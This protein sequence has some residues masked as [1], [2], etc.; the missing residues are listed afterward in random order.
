MKVVTP[1]NARKN[2]YGIIR[3]VVSDSKPVEIASTKSEKESVIVISKADWDAI[4]ETLYLQQVGVLD[5]I[6]N[7]EDEES[8]E[9]G[10]IDW[11]TM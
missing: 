2:L 4:Q 1:T 3:S 6:K 9:L 7:H 5:D 10:E 8:E 11:N